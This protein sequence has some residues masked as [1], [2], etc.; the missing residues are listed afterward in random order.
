M[1]CDVL[2][3]GA[4]M[5]G[6][7]A[8]QQLQRIGRTV[9]VLE[10]R[11]RLGGRICTD[12][13][14]G[15]PLD[16]G[17]A[18]IHGIRDNPVADL[19]RAIGVGWRE[20]DFSRAQIWHAQAADLPALLGDSQAF[21]HGV[22]LYENTLQH[23]AAGVVGLGINL[24]QAV[25]ALPT[26][27]DWP[28]DVRAGWQYAAHIRTQLLQNADL[29]EIDSLLDG[30]YQTLFGG[31]MLP[32][33]GYQPLLSAVAAGVAVQLETVVQQIRW[34]PGSVQVQSNRGTFSA[35]RCLITLPL[36]VL[37]AGTVAF[38]PLLPPEKQL[39]IQR[40]GMGKYEKLLLRFA[41]PF[42]QRESVRVPH[43][44]RFAP[45]VGQ[46][47]FFQSW[48]NHA[49]HSG[50]PILAT[51]H[52]GSRAA[53]LNTLPD[54]LVVEWALR[55]LRQMFG[56]VIPDPLDYIRTR[57][58]DDPYTQGGYSFQKVGQQPFD[59]Q[60]LAA[61][62]AQTLFFAGEATHAQHFSTVHGAYASGLRAVGEMF[63]Y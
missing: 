1:D 58:A 47:D 7:A 18:W 33:G 25:A 22:A 35:A 27:A 45:A 60:W 6:L 30:A 63:G 24:A 32:A 16:L 43:V 53:Q 41:Q 4:G 9:L 54:A 29:V 14:W 56:A 28:V 44:L 15:L 36:G 52:A 38:E 48:I 26:P 8:A 31:D 62:L 17:A 19:A 12:A 11:K 3:I 20:T 49:Y 51:Q 21:A 13:R 2:V 50:Q 46:P 37:K 23:N 59:R 57:W 39:A 34:Q 5:A 55:A 61:P 42:W 40:I 10:A